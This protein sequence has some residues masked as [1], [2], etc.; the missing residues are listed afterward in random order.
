MP[1]GK[2]VLNRVNMQMGLYENV[3]G[4]QKE[5]ASWQMEGREVW[6]WSGPGQSDESVRVITGIMESGEEEEEETG[7]LC[8]WATVQ[9]SVFRDETEAHIKQTWETG[10]R[11][12]G[13]EEANWG[14]NTN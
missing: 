2:V 14:E 6:D 11:M 7:M 1:S 5:K 8:S 12:A 13:E 10:K 3:A 4:S 9:C